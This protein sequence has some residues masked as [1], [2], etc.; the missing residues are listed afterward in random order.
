MNTIVTPA[1]NK[2]KAAI[3]KLIYV[4]W[5]MTAN[6]NE[7]EVLVTHEEISD[8]AM[9]ANDRDILLEMLVDINKC[10]FSK[11]TEEREKW[12]HRSSSEIMN[13]EVPKDLKKAY[14]ELLF[15]NGSREKTAY[16]SN[17]NW[18]NFAYPYTRGRILAYRY[19][20]PDGTFL[21]PNFTRWFPELHTTTTMPPHLKGKKVKVYTFQGNYSDCVEWFDWGERSNPHQNIYAYEIMN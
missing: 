3:G 14:M 15:E 21:T 8:A 20:N 9:V 5:S 19:I 12:I 2:F 13:E 10:L 6:G 4:K 11:Q 7:G 1:I 17:Y 16:P 18:S